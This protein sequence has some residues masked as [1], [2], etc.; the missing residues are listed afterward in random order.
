VDNENIHCAI[1][2]YHDYII[3]SCVLSLS[4]LTQSGVHCCE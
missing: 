3:S 1:V 2:L 4:A